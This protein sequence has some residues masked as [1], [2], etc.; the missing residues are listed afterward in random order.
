MINKNNHIHE[1]SSFMSEDEWNLDLVVK[2]KI[3]KNKTVKNE[4]QRALKSIAKAIA[5]K[6]GNNEII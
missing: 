4:K 1:E 3:D 6:T 2:P 5:L